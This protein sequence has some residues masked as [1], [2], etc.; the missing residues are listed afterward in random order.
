MAPGNSR[1]EAPTSR[2][3]PRGP[4][5]PTPAPCTAGAP[6]KCCR[7]LRGAP[8]SVICHCCMSCRDPV[9]LSPLRN[10]GLCGRS[11]SALS[12]ATSSWPTAVPGT[13]WQQHSLKG[14]RAAGCSPGAQSCRCW[15]PER[16][17]AASANRTVKPGRGGG[18]ERADPAQA[19]SWDVHKPGARGPPRPWRPAAGTGQGHSVVFRKTRRGGR[20]DFGLWWRVLQTRTGE[21]G[22]SRDLAH[23][24]SSAWGNDASAL[25]PNTPAEL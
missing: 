16:V 20:A 9:C 4:H 6:R 11:G 10:A 12:G 17:G 19:P 2:L 1:S 14:H 18:A 3:L 25:N 7:P 23:P 24:G 8:S 13:W 15:P 21:C 5:T 22:A